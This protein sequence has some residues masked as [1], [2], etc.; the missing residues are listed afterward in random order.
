MYEAE[1]LSSKYQ[2]FKR[3]RK[4]IRALKHKDYKLTWRV[5]LPY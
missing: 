2:L 3:K 4:S 1:I 5:I